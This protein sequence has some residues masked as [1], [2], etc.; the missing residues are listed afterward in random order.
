LG[1]GWQKI[2]AWD[3][4]LLWFLILGLLAAALLVIGQAGNGRWLGVLIN[5]QFKMS[6][7]RLQIVL[8][9]LLVLSAYITIAIHRLSG[10]LVAMDASAIA[11]CTQ[12]L[13]RAPASAEECGGGVINITFPPELLLAMG[14][15]AASFAGASI[16]QSNKKGKS[17]DIVAK[18][19]RIAMEQANVQKARDAT[20]AA[21]DAMQEARLKLEQ[22]AETAA[23]GGQGAVM[24]KAVEEQNFN[25][26]A[27]AYK[28]TQIELERANE[29][30]K[31]AQE[32][33]QKVETEA[34]GVLHK[35]ASASDA[36]FTD[37]FMGDELGNVKLVDMSKVQMFFLTLVV[38][39]IY[40]VA[41]AVTLHDA[42][43]MMDPISY[44]FPI[45][46]DTLNSLL[47]ISHGT[48]LSVKTVDHTK[49]N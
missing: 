22:A 38:V 9:T 48:Y 1:R 27:L 25:K 47:A 24:T 36:R 45:F 42:A 10:H 46:S 34:E 41:V 35:N 49:T 15:S 16:I 31:R 30:L 19:D 39:V 14:I 7:S 4:V 5:T 17:V 44:D 26:A 29:D 3:P 6:L 8:W 20:D 12:T 33:K 13:G 37:L 21:Y 32:E 23:A 18:N 43:A 11:N 40:G 2:L 28:L